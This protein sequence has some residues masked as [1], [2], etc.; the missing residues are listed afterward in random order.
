MLQ[1]NKVYDAKL[2]FSQYTEE[3]PMS[4]SSSLTGFFLHVKHEPELTNDNIIGYKMLKSQ[5][6]MHKLPH[7]QCFAELFK[8][9]KNKKMQFVKQEK[10]AHI[11]R[12]RRQSE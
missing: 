4:F 2:V 12:E 8:R 6:K 7:V 3:T 11:L 1:C 10:Q 9:L 5:C